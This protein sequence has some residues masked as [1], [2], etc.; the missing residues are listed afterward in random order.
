VQRVVGV[1]ISAASIESAIANARRNGVSNVRFIRN[2][3]T[4][5]SLSSIMRLISPSDLVLLDPPRGGTGEGVIE[6]IA[7]KRPGE[8]LHIFCNVDLIPAE[9]AR[10]RASGYRLSRALPFDMF[11]GTSVIEVMGLLRHKDHV[12]GV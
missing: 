4:P 8:V 10:W 1:E 2:D 3:I 9:I 11:P 5:S 7:A 6:Y 12:E